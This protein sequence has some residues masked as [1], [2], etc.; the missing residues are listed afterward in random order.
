MEVSWTT[1]CLVLFRSYTGP[2]GSRY[3]QLSA[4]KLG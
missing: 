3:E 2:H 4:A 1:A